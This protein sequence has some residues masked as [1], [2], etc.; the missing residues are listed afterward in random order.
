MQLSKFTDYTFRTLIYLGRN[1]DKN[2]IVRE[3]AKELDIS[4]QHLKK[5]VNNLSRNKYIISTKGRSGGLRLAL[6]PK[7]INLGEVINLTGENLNI[8]QCMNNTE[9]CPLK[10]S[11]CK[12]KSIV[13]NSLKA[14][15]DELGKYTLKDIL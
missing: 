5:V 8:V 9:L 4:E 15:I 14:F 2:V 12:L 7:D 11:G 1:E 6:E 3:L 13:N 10:D